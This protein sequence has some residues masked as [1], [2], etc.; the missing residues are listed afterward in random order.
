MR[1]LIAE[2]RWFVVPV[3]VAAVAGAVVLLTVPKAPLHLWINQWHCAAADS[4]FRYYTLLGDGWAVVGL[5]LVLLF[6]RFRDALTVAISNILGLIVTQVL[7]HGPF[8]DC[9]R[10]AEYFKDTAQLHL[11]PGVEML[12]YN[13]FPSGHAT[14]AFATGLCLAVMVERP[15]AKTALFLFSLTLAFSRVF[16]SQHFFGDIYAGALFGLLLSGVV[17]LVVDSPEKNAPWMDRSVR[18]FLH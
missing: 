3:V 2:N 16:L 11:V 9:V 7:K 5:V 15:S 6:V 17:I 18:S 12:L 14:T 1:T 4:F 13:S 10:P 8:A